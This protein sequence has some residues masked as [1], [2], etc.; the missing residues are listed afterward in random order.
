MEVVLFVTGIR[1]VER[2]PEKRLDAVGLG[3]TQFD[4]VTAKTKPADLSDSMRVAAGGV[5][6]RELHAVRHADARQRRSVAVDDTREYG[7]AASGGNG[8]GRS[9]PAG[10]RPSVRLRKAHFA[11]RFHF[12][13]SSLSR[14]FP[15][16]SGIEI[17]EILPPV[18]GS[19][20]PGSGRR[21]SFSLSKTRTRTSSGFFLLR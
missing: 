4:G 12:V 20:S 14:G 18:V 9:P 6:R 13:A 7:L 3:A 10:R 1:L 8:P 11:N 15:Y 17:P 21:S 2:R 16:D 5:G 19:P